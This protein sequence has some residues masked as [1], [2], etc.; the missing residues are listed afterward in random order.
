M[1]PKNVLI[2]MSDEHTRAAT[3]CYGSDIA[4]TPNLDKLAA[5]GAR[6]DSAYTPCP[7]CV[8]ARAAFATGKYVHQIETWDNA[9]AFDGSMP[10]WHSLLRERGHQT[11]S[12]GKLHF[13]STE[14]DNGF[15]DE[16]ISM[17]LVEAK[18]DLLGL[19]RDEDTVKRGASRKMA[20]MA[21]PGESMYTRYDRDITSD[22]IAW[23]YEEA[24]KHKDKPWVLFV[25]WVAPH[26]PLTAP[27]QHFYRY[28]NQD[29]PAPKLYNL[30]NTPIHPYV[31]DYRKIFAYDEYFETRDM[32]KR[33]QAG[34]LG[35]VS[36]MDEQV[37]LVLAALESAGLKD[38][39]R[40]VYTTDHGDNMGSRGAWGKSLMYEEAVAVPLIVSGP[41]IPS[42]AVVETPANLLDV[43]PFIME[44]A[45]ERDS[46]TVPGDI[47]G[48][49]V[50][51]LID[52]SEP[53]RVAFSEYH[54]M[55]SKKAAFMIRKG[56][57]K[58]VHYVDYPAQL[59]NL[60]AD[61]EEVNDRADDP[62]C[63][64]LRKDLLDELLKICDPVKV[65]K[66]ARARQARMIE[67]N[68]GKQPII[69]RG[70]LGFS[71]PP[72]VQPM[73]N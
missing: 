25:S 53:D 28:Y 56:D 17:H 27:S 59:F 12:I 61:P 11:V 22:A 5:S 14:D 66:A 8:P 71:V 47:P 73:F 63:A 55:G 52:G 13:R 44:S 58:L 18:G 54:A 41:D 50:V 32:V 57:W 19:I 9:T 1:E 43:Y 30:R 51:D 33:A 68:G 4:R 20:Q 2:L 6:F 46:E 10:S 67:E 15:S 29:L 65:D 31:D 37:G 38:A 70:D 72:G 3:G 24:P 62:A 48:T 23:L 69:E 42:G 34:Y 45:G 60:K 26:F 49:S 64:S 40:I 36:F 7:V 21:G 16:R 39:T 35:L